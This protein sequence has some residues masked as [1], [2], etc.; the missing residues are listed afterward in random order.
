MSNGIGNVLVQDPA[1]GYPQYVN[2]IEKMRSQIWVL[3][4]HFE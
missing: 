2:A 3:A 1:P 4:F